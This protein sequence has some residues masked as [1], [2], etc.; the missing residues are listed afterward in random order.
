[1]KNLLLILYIFSACNFGISQSENTSAQE[2]PDFSIPIS[3]DSLVKLYAFIDLLPPFELTKIRESYIYRSRVAPTYQNKEILM[4]I[5]KA[6][7]T[8]KKEEK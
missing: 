7:V 5:E 4:Y 2:K 8:T 1:M 6:I 3:Q